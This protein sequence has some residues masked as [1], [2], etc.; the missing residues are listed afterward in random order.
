MANTLETKTP[1]QLSAALQSYNDHQ[2]TIPDQFTVL[3]EYLHDLPVGEFCGSFR[4]LQKIVTGVY[5]Y[6]RENPQTIGLVAADK[7][8]GTLT[9]QTSQH[10]SCVKK[11]LYAAGRFSAFESHA[12]V[13]SFNDF[14]NA[15]MTYFR[16]CSV[17]LSEKINVYEPDKQRKFFQSK[18]LRAVFACLEAF[19][20][21][22]GGIGAEA[23]DITAITIRYPRRPS[24]IPVIKAFA[25]PRICRVSFGLDYT[26]FNHRVF[27]H[28]AEA[29]LPLKDLYSFTLLPDA[30]KVFMQQLD[31][32]MRMAGTNYGEAAG[33]WYHGTLPCQYNYKNKVRILQNVEHGL[34]PYAVLRYKPRERIERLLASIPEAVLSG[35]GRC[36]GCVKGECGTRVTAAVPGGKKYVLCTGWLA[37]PPIPEAVPFIVKA[38]KI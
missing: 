20:F 24:V 37:F 8:T 4:E 2:G 27:A 15:Y 14:M 19:G 23:H 25:A 9:V 30:H 7:K 18:H 1:E 38:Y 32:A 12:L 5:D 17:E 10:I 35:M 11:L 13:I 36:R 34:M 33:G 29:R 6:L 28:G 26:K 21:E 16:N 3:D 22:M 31:E